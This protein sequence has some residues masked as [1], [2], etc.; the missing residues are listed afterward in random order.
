MANFSG[1]NISNFSSN[2]SSELGDVAFFLANIPECLPYVIL[3]LLGATIG[4]LGTICYKKS[5][6]KKNKKKLKLYLFRKPNGNVDNYREQRITLSHLYSHVQSRFDRH[7]CERIC[8]SSS[9]F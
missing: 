9:D 8:R 5:I 4:I 1:L 7:Y 6:K 2:E 3:L